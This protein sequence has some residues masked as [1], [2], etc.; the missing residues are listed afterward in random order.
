MET[1]FSQRMAQLDAAWHDAMR[2]AQACAAR[3]EELARG[4]A[5]ALGA[6]AF[7]R[8]LSSACSAAA[9]PP[10]REAGR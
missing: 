2:D 10:C 5:K 7:Y 6:L 3:E 1:S 9:V 4:R 8:G